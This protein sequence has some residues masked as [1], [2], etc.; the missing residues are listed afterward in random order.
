[1]DDRMDLTPSQR[2][3]IEHVTAWAKNQRQDA[4]ATI[5]H[6]LNMSN[7]SRERWRQ[8]VRHVKVHARIGLQFHPDRPDA[9]MRTVA[10]ALLEDGIYKSQFETLISNGSVTAYPGGERDL[11]EKRLFGG[12][13]HRKGVISKDQNMGRFT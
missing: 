11:W 12:A 3:A 6:I 4:D 5:T 2:S 7:I 9:S 13:Y 8:A 1:M 10:E